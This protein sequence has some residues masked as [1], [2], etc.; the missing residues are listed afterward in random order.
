MRHGVTL[1]LVVVLV[2]APAS[3]PLAAADAPGGSPV[4]SPGGGVVGVDGAIAANYD[5]PQDP[6]E[7]VLGWE[8][9]YWHNESIPV[10]P[11]DGYNETELN[12]MISRSMARVEYIRGLEFTQTPNV[13]LITR[14]EYREF[15]NSLYSGALNVTTKGRLHQNTKF[16]S[17]FLVSEEESYFAD[18]VENRGGFAAAFHINEDI[19]EY[20]FSEGDIGIVVSEGGQAENIPEPTLGHELYHFVQNNRFDNTKFSGGPTEEAARVNTSI[21]E[22][23]ATYVGQTYEERC[24]AEWDCLPTSQGD[25]PSFANLGLVFLDLGPYSRTATLFDRLRE[26]GGVEAMNSLYENPP[27]STEQ[28]MHPKKYPDDVPTD[29]TLEDRSTEAWAKQTFENGVD[30]A[31]FGEVGLFVMLWFPS[32]QARQRVAIDP[33]YPFTG[34]QGNT[35]VRYDYS[36]PASAGWDGDKMFV[37]TNETSPE[38][39][40][41][42]YVWKLVWDSPEDAAEFRDA[43]TKV[44]EY[45]GGERVGV[46]ENTW[47]IPE[48]R[49]FDDAFHVVTEGDTTVIVNAPSVEDLDEV[50]TN[51]DLSAAMRTPSPSPTSAESP[52]ATPTE[53]PSGETTTTGMTNTEPTTGG[54]A[55]EA[56]D[57]T[58]AGAD[59]AATD[60]DETTRTPVTPGFG[61]LGAALAVLIAL[62]LSRRLN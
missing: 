17:L 8:N 40:E 10:T 46:S 43:Y 33:N 21:T 38:T 18:L 5:G 61:L 53:P 36:H 62:L 41:T 54:S 1:A 19:P 28:F 39:N 51:I 58:T 6:E 30:Y 12:V 35:Y 15:T 45:H 55:G 34:A 20:G 59:G 56:T 11:A 27:A 9:G 47:R 13:T 48:N 16:E 22:G 50:R 14:Q 2:L 3:A 26:E 25:P 4:A 57:E 60:T 7:D 29:V 31:T 23:D 52:T 42:G 37:Y 49:Q 44:L 24:G 32:Y